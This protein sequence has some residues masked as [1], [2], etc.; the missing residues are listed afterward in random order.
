M[1]A[2]PSAEDAAVDNVWFIGGMNDYFEY[3]TTVDQLDTTGFVA[4]LP[5]EL[6][7]G[8]TG[9]SAYWNED[10]NNVIVVG[11]YTADRAWKNIPEIAAN[12]GM[13][14]IQCPGT[15]MNVSR[16]GQ[17]LEVVGSEI[18]S[19]RMV[20]FG[21]T[22]QE[23]TLTFDEPLRPMLSDLAIWQLADAATGAAITVKA[24]ELSDDFKTVT[25][26]LNGA[27]LNTTTGK[28]S[29]ILDYTASEN[30]VLVDW[31][32]NVVDFRVDGGYATTDDAANP[33]VLNSSINTTED[34]A[35][36]GA[37]FFHDRNDP[38]RT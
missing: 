28:V 12:D 11:G 25:L 27:D 35:V 20:L 19:K 29:L 14:W 32:G 36:S 13:T 26:T 37:L 3:Q 2:V 10:L 17:H 6:N 18:N 9:A 21:G 24:L 7:I 1:I 16:I 23:P 4:T 31:A 15:A 33:V 8:R 38:R 34:A 22:D 30:G 5:G